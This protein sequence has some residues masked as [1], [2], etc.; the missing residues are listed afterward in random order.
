MLK[1]SGGYANNKDGDA[2]AYHPGSP[3]FVEAQYANMAKIPVAADAR[4]STMSYGADSHR[5]S[6]PPPM[7]GGNAMIGMMLNGQNT[8]S[9]PGSLN[10]AWPI[11]SPKYG[12]RYEMDPTATMANDARYVHALLRNPS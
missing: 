7:D 8:F 1:H 9:S 10:G 2:A 12:D 6:S 5:S 3:G 4:F 11:T